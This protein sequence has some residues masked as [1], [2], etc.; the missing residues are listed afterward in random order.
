L[1]SP[2]ERCHAGVVDL[3]A[4]IE[5]VAESP[6][7]LSFV[8][9]IEPRAPLEDNSGDVTESVPHESCQ[10]AHQNQRPIISMSL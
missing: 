6:P 7:R 10:R 3:Q 5:E 1:R 9:Y 2:P 4:D 8:D